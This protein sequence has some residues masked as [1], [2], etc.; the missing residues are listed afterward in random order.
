VIA[1]LLT[2]LF[3]RLTRPG[4]HALAALDDPG[5]RR[6][7]PGAASADLAGLAEDPSRKHPTPAD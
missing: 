3:S 7:C 4:A 1:R 2:R 5:A 6:D